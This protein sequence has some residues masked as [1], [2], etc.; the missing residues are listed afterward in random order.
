MGESVYGAAWYTLSTLRTRAH[1]ADRTHNTHQTDGNKTRRRRI[2]IWRIPQ[3]NRKQRDEVVIILFPPPYVPFYSSKGLFSFL[4]AFL[5]D[6]GE[7][8]GKARQTRQAATTRKQA[9]AYTAHYRSAQYTRESSTCAVHIT[10]VAGSTQAV[11]RAGR[12][13][14]GG[15]PAKSDDRT[16]G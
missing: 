14:E 13:A 4:F 3:K 11:G 15:D 8:Q 7:T 9:A 1:K 6:L 2:P 10:R 12:P 5:R 16:L